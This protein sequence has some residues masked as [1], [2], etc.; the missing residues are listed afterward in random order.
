MFYWVNFNDSTTIKIRKTSSSILK[1]KDILT[2]EM[3]E[4]EHKA[5]KTMEEK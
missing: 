2:D 1:K 5:P 3:L 4:A